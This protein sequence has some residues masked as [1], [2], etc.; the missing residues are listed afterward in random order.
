MFKLFLVKAELIAITFM[1]IVC[2]IIQST[3]AADF[4]TAAALA[5]ALVGQAGSSGQAPKEN[6]SAGGSTPTPNPQPARSTPPSPI[7]IKVKPEV[8]TQLRAQGPQAITPQIQTAIKTKQADYTVV[9]GGQPVIR[10]DI[11]ITITAEGSD[12]PVLEYT[13]VQQPNGQTSLRLSGDTFHGQF[14]REGESH[15]FSTFGIEVKAVITNVSTDPN[16]VQLMP[17]IAEV[18]AKEGA[19]QVTFTPEGKTERTTVEKLAE[20]TWYKASQNPEIVY[21]A[22]QILGEK[23]QGVYGKIPLR[24]ALNDATRPTDLVR[25]V[26]MGMTQEGN[27]IDGDILFRINKLATNDL[28]PNNSLT[29]IKYRDALDSPDPK[30]PV[31]HD[32]GKPVWIDL[33]VGDVTAVERLGTVEGGVFGIKTTQIKIWAWPDDAAATAA[34]LRTVKSG[35]KLY[36]LDGIQR[37]I[38]FDV[39]DGTQIKPFTFKPIDGVT[40][41]NP[42]KIPDATP[43]NPTSFFQYRQ[44]FEQP[45]TLNN[46]YLQPLEQRISPSMYN[47]LSSWEEVKK[48]RLEG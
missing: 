25:T 1:V 46:W 17:I 15:P 6:A 8:V 22:N 13:T 18:F 30:K 9:Q 37:E 40:P 43:A 36:M 2:A 12:K 28:D 44:R 14:R 5:P 33:K 23:W 21:L 20:G 34:Q 39:G 19:L 31:W 3:Y 4:G 26:A 48:D 42:L 16:A 11:R 7:A 35:E 32:L 27:L 45:G 38:K 47:F 10:P 24:Y 41:R 29:A